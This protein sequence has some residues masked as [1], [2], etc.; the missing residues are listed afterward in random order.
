MVDEQSWCSVVVLAPMVQRCSCVLYAT[1]LC[2]LEKNR[3]GG[4]EGRGDAAAAS[5]LPAA[6]QH[7]CVHA[8]TAVQRCCAQRHCTALHCIDVKKKKGRE[9]PVKKNI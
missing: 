4:G 7:G 2:G 5:F 6:H 3:K 8:E 1:L 9:E